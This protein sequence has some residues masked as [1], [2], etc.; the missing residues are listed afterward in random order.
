[1]DLSKEIL[2]LQDMEALIYKVDNQLIMKYLELNIIRLRLRV[3][4][5]YREWLW[6]VIR[7]LGYYVLDGGLS[8][9][10]DKPTTKNRVQI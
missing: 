9:V 5:A 7:M 4:C 1:M 10:D 2:L 3:Y 8:N 6:N